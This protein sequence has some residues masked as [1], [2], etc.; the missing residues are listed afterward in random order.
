VP[1][2]APAPAAPA[3]DVTRYPDEQPLTGNATTSNDV[4]ARKQTNVQ[5]EIVQ[6][7]AHGSPVTRVARSGNWTLVSW[8]RTDGD[9]MGWVETNKAFA[10]NDEDY[11]RTIPDRV[12]R[13]GRKQGILR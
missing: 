11:K 4:P 9:K 13:E 10:N 3:S 8:K 7:L 2:P 12:I 6:N 1:A 5:S